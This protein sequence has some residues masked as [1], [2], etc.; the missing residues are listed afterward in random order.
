[1][2]LRLEDLTLREKIGQTAIFYHKMLENIPDPEAYFTNNPVGC[3]WPMGHSK[4]IYRQ[5]ETLLG[6]PGLEGRKDHMN[7]DYIN[8]LNRCMRVP[9]IPAI[10]ATAGIPAS[11]YEDHPELPT[12]TGLGATRDPEL[13]Y[14]YGKALGEDLRSIG[15]RWIWSPVADNAG[16]CIGSRSLSA[17]IENNCRM[18]PAFIHGVQSAGVAT[19]V[20]HFP[21]KD[22]Y[23]YRDSHF[24]TA[25]YSESFEYW[26]K[27]QGREFQAC[28]DAG[29]DAVMVGHTTFR[30][31]DDTRVNGM[32]LP[33]TLSHKVITGLIKEKMGFSGVV[34]TDDISM[35]ALTA[36]YPMEK[37]YVEL[38]RAGIDMVLGPRHLNYID[39]VEEAVRSGDLPESRIDD[40]CSRV[41]RM[42]EK[43]GLLEKA[44]IPY[45]T[46]TR[47]MELREAFHK[48][49]QDIAEKGLTLAANRT[50]FLPLAQEKIRNVK[51]VYIGYS[52]ECYEKLQYAVEEFARYGARCDVQRGFAIEDN[53]TLD[54]YDLI[55]Y[56]TYIGF[57]KPLGGRA[58]FG[59]EC[60]MMRRI[61]T[62]C[63]EKSIGVSFGDTDIFFNYFT[64]AHT[65]INCYS[66]NPE[67]MEAFVK[68]LYGDVQFIAY[69]PYPLNPIKRTDDVYA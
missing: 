47:R 69:N 63:T 27:T 50:G 38:L 29:S 62:K 64:A 31:V 1:M 5:V 67:T 14:R 60:E 17:D 6:N 36:I 13:A 2:K 28:F 42:K 26:E 35:K 48:V 22:P 4:E 51:I 54:Q 33:S 46:E 8:L 44:H 45:P 56:A 53:D 18:L 30:A 57:H 34:L 20:K 61:M 19:A 65:F 9:V 15:F 10:D 7:I 16:H 59:A 43:Y 39:I 11:K 68:G 12:G 49:S 41:L 32:L 21:G 66:I 37:L 23:E 52:D 55:I 58:F 3:S 40:A 24:C 25:G